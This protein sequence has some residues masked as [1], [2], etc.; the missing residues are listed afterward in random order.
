MGYFKREY[1][2]AKLFYHYFSTYLG[3]FLIP[4]LLFFIVSV[5]LS[6]N[7]LNNEIQENLIVHSKQIADS[8]EMTVK[9][10]DASTYLSKRERSLLAENIKSDAMLQREIVDI[11]WKNLNANYNLFDIVY[12]NKDEGIILDSFNSYSIEYAESQL[13]TIEG[14]SFLQVMENQ[15]L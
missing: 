5:G 13:K 12:Y 3:V 8:V 6:V 15:N 1:G 9:D 10:I 2:G 4:V 7:K 11:L 14:E